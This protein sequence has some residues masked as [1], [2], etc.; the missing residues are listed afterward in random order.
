MARP[1]HWETYRKPKRI[2]IKVEEKL[3]LRRVQVASIEAPSI[4]NIHFE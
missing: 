1:L 2:L 3:G 4:F